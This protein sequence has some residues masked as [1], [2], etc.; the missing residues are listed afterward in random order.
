MLFR[1]HLAVSSLVLLPLA[2]N[3]S[4]N[5]IELIT[6]LSVGL[7]GALAPDIDEP[8]SF[9]GKR[10]PI[11]SHIIK[12]L[13]K[14]R[15]VVHSLISIPFIIFMIF[16]INGLLL[17]LSRD[18]LIS[19]NVG[20]FFIIGWSL[21][22]LEDSFSKSGIKWFLP[23]NNKSFKSGKILTF[24]NKKLDFSY[25]TGSMYEHLI[26]GVALLMLAYMFNLYELQHLRSLIPFNI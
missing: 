12:M 5:E 18:I 4:N 7:I 9:V 20:L 8:E 17:T 10:V 15:G 3:Q 22:L 19:F 16:V 6:Y 23:F 1:S 11:V 26:L 14:H 2:V 25:K 24:I 13:F 21:H